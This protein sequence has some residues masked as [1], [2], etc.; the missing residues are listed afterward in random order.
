[1]YEPT[2]ALSDRETELLFAMIERLKRD[3]VGIIYISHRLS[4]GFA[5][6]DRITVR[7]DGRRIASLLPGETTPDKLVTLMVGR[8]VDATYTRPD[9]PLPGKVVLEV[10]NLSATTGFSDVSLTVRAGEIVGL[11]GLVG[12]GGRGGAPAR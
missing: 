8:E 2:A 11:W 5:L 3:G 4:G 9:R 1:M 7:R 10:K 6:G 12:S